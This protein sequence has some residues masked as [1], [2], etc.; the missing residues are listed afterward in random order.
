MESMDSVGQQHVVWIGYTTEYRSGGAALQRAAEDLGRRQRELGRH[1]I[2]VAVERKREFV[3][4]MA[5][6]SREQQQIDELHLLTHSGLY[7]PMFGTTQWPEQFSPHEW[8]ALQIPFAAGAE[9]YFHACRSARWFAPFFARTFSVPASGYH[10]YTTF[11]GAPDRF[12][13]PRWRDP[14]AHVWLVGFAGR[15][16]HGLVASL[17]KYS[18]W[19]LSEPFKRF[20][21]EQVDGSYDAVAK[22]YDEVFDDIAV[23]TDEID[24]LDAHL[25]PGRP[26]VLDLG[27]GNGALLQRWK[28]RIGASVGIDAS[29]AMLERAKLRNS[30]ASNLRFVQVD[31]PTLPLSDQS[32]DVVVSML[33][34]R[35]LDW[36]PMM[37]EIRR[38][39]VADGRLLLVDMAARAPRWYQ[40]PRVLFDGIRARLGRNRRFDRHLRQL[41][42]DPAWQTMLQHNP[43]RAEHEYLWYLRSRFPDRS[44]QVLNVGRTA[45]ILA[46][47][48][49]PISAM[50]ASELTWP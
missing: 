35:Y 30:Q 12:R 15:T 34:F 47:D 4:E 1:V 28:D 24:W 48:S 18:G 41:V 42:D 31:G 13:F 39:L 50:R 37:A 8:R 32:V 6:L 3:E 36:D 17:A 2:C 11:T 38:V 14:K 16:S 5:R 43:M 27:C 23:R 19:A 33:S 9:A 25:P 20:T 22:R 7:G 45:R 10:W 29:P 44:V 40:W 26:R 21:A 49:G 46:F